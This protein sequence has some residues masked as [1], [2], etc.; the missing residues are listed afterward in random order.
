MNSLIFIID[1]EFII[2]TDYDDYSFMM[3]WPIIK[4]SLITSGVFIDSHS[5]YPFLLKDRTASRYV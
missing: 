1:I 4:D 2:N 5:L 3:G